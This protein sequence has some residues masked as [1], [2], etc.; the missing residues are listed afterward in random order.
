MAQEYQNILSPVEVGPITM[1]NRIYF[2]AHAT[3]FLPLHAGVNDQSIAYYEARAKGGAAA[4]ISGCHLIGP[5]STFTPNPP[6]NLADE[7]TIP[8]LKRCADAIHQHGAKV[9]CQLGAIGRLA[10]TRPFG[11]VTWGA[12]PVR[13]DFPPI[14]WEIP[15]EMEIE[16]IQEIVQLYGKAAKNVKAAGYDGVEILGSGGLLNH[17]F[18][19]PKI[20]RRKDEYGGSLEKR[21][22]LQFECI[23]AVKESIGNDMILGFKMPGDDF[24]DGGITLDEGKEIACALEDTGKLDYLTVVGGIYINIPTHVPTMYYPLGPF[25]YLAS[26]VRKTVRKI[27]VNC[28]GRVNDPTFA[29]KIIADGHADMVGMV[30]ALIADPEFVNKARE[31]RED[32]IRRCVG[33]SEAC[34]GR[35]RR[36]FHVSCAYNPQAGRELQFPIVPATTKKRVMVVGGGVAG[37]ETARVA[38]LRGHKVSLYERES[39]LGGQV[40]I[41]S[42]ATGRTDFDEMP[43]YYTYQMGLLG[44]DVHLETEVT[45]EMVM[46]VNPDAVVVATG[47]VPRELDVPGGDQN[48]VVEPRAVLQGKVEVGQ[49]VLVIAGEHNMQALSTAETLAE[50]G[51]KVRV[52]TEAFYAGSQAPFGDCS[53]VHSRL[54]RAGVTITTL[55]TVK[56]I[57]GQTV[58]TSNVLTGEEGRIEGVDTVVAAMGGEADCAL[59]RSLKGKVKEL[60]AVGDCTQPRLIPQTTLDGL[61]V[62]TKL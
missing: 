45:P 11:G 44:V 30:R 43:R 42:K 29:D 3:V 53:N 4:V 48:K 20:N 21:L 22:R 57:Q 35:Y 16:E 49:N 31:G 13:L 5:I 58:I 39:E 34:Y 33:C 55:T 15:H 26:E 41:A 32:E 52:L 24:V 1:R 61:R 36:G 37:L 46:K 23:D 17:Q 10:E 18:L 7:R 9:I 54:L 27:N 19:S 56:E 12:S 50:R 60:Y 47:S 59:Y 38:A 8:D 51:K 6:S 40:R 14:T 62:G 2:A 28:M 25:V